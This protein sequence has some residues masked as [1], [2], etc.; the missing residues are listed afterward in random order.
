L[1][2]EK[3][4]DFLFLKVTFESNAAGHDSGELG[5][6]HDVGTG[7]SGHVLFHHL[8]GKPSD[9]GGQAGKGGGIHDRLHELV[10]RHDISSAFFI[11]KSEKRLPAFQQSL[12]LKAELNFL[13]AS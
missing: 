3:N 12:Q 11:F 7:V 6:V 10:V 1:S 9:A 13:D 2:R 5:I 8:F 4:L